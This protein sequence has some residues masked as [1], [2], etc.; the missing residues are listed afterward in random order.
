MKPRTLLSR[1]SNRFENLA[2]AF[3]VVINPGVLEYAR[4]AGYSTFLIQQPDLPNARPATPNA[5]RTII[6]DA[7]LCAILPYFASV[8]PDRDIVLCLASQRPES[9]LHG[10]IPAEL[11]FIRVHQ[12][13]ED[14]GSEG[15]VLRHRPLVNRNHQRKD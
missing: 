5:R 10:G 9:A 8:V 1:R 11:G 12:T 3:T 2:F 13:K 4:L 6:R 7:P 14:L 15:V